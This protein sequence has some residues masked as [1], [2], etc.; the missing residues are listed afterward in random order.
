MHESAP[1]SAATHQDIKTPRMLEIPAAQGDWGI[2]NYGLGWEITT[3]HGSTV[4]KHNGGTQNFGAN[5]LWMSDIK[6]G[7][8]ALANAV[9]SGSFVED[10]LTKK[11]VEDRLRVPHKDR[12]DDGQDE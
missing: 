7:V 11:L 10:L 3:F 8:V 6:I 4:Y 1:F 9:D 5:V 2:S 12:P